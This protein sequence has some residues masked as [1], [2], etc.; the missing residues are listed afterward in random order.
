M[1]G[2]TCSD[3]IPMK[4]SMARSRTALACLIFVAGLT[5]ISRIPLGAE[6][7]ID[8]INIYR[9]VPGIIDVDLPYPSPEIQTLL[10]SDTVLIGKIVRLS[11]AAKSDAE[12]LQ[13]MVEN[14]LVL[15]GDPAGKR[16]FIQ[17]LQGPSRNV[18]TT[19]P[20]Q[21]VHENA[22]YLFFLANL[23]NNDFAPIQLERFALR[24]SDIPRE[25]KEKRLAL[26]EALRA[27][28]RAHLHDTDDAIAFLWI[29]FLGAIYDDKRDARL[30]MDLA[31]DRRFTFRGFAMATLLKHGNLSKLDEAADYVTELEKR[32]A[33]T[34]WIRAGQ[35]ICG[36][37]EGLKSEWLT[38]DFRPLLK[39][40]NTALQQAV[41]RVI[42]RSKDQSWIR[43]LESVMTAGRT[44][45]Q[46]RYECLKAICQISEGY[47]C[48]GMET[49]TANPARYIAEWKEWQRQNEEKTRKHNE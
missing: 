36:Q 35:A 37:I 3:Q 43:H 45:I 22:T 46:I 4:T 7:L 33:R 19:H 21:I 48:P 28:G 23:G 2:D 27:L 34:E 32:P 25:L 40:R 5:G 49:F 44:D 11:A 42:A 6:A 47:P 38:P 13:A 10:R 39:S 26:D 24:V 17:R 14:P 18:V 29:D 9:E 20:A 30:F 16:I 8:S 31:A 15:K 1:T 41:I 12:Q